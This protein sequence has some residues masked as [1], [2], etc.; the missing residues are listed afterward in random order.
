M[1][2]VALLYICR[3]CLHVGRQRGRGGCCL[4]CVVLV[5]SRFT[6]SLLKVAAV[7]KYDYYYKDPRILLRRGV[8]VCS[9][10]GCHFLPEYILK[11]NSPWLSSSASLFPHVVTKHRHLTIFSCESVFEQWGVCMYSFIYLFMYVSELVCVQSKCR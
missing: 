2:M 6:H 10:P 11:H 5:N 4:L 1:V 7:C 9:L 3:C 8:Y